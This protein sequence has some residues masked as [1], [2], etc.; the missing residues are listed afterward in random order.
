MKIILNSNNLAF[1]IGEHF[2]VTENGI[3]LANGAVNSSYTS[4][5][6]TVI[7]TDIIPDPP[8]PFAWKWE[9]ETWIVANQE[10]IDAYLVDQNINFNAE[11]S[12]KRSQAYIV[13]SDPLFFKA[14]RGEG[15]MAD[16]EAKVAQIKARYPKISPKL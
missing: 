16:W 1:F 10:A 7:E 5:N 8:I 3:T 13:E 15:T 6:T 11:Q 4:N 2:T 9:N 14:Q 12:Q